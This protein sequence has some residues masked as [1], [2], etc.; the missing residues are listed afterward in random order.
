MHRELLLKAFEK[1]RGELEFEGHKEPSDSKCALHLSEI[2]SETFPYGERSLRD[3]Y[4]EARKSGEGDISIP[5]PQ[6]LLALAKYLGYENYS[7]F[8]IKNR[9]DEVK[10]IPNEGKGPAKKNKLLLVVIGLFSIIFISYSGYQYFNKQRWMEWEGTHFVETSFDSQ[11]L[12]NGNLR[13]FNEELGN[14]KK[15]TPNCET[16]FFNDDGSVRVWYGKN[17]EGMHEYFTN[18]GLHPET[19]K[20]LKPITKY[21]IGKYI[22]VENIK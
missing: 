15:I 21:I 19:G 18:H 2:I 6:V 20:T 17:K 10:R 9:I 13:E 14:F 22:C 12:K 16:E 3:F 8:L 11:K 7:D 4:N 1:V 5:Q